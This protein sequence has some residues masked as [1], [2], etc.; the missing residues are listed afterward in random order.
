MQLGTS[1]FLIAVGAILRYAVTTTA[2]GFS[3]HT[4]GMILMVVG[5]IG[6]VLSLLLTSI[7]AGRRDD[8]VARRT[9]VRDREVL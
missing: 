4:A 2:T 3:I 5:V 9:V 1:I 6:L 7:W 8:V